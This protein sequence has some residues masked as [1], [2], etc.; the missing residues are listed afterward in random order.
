MTDIAS[1][2]WGVASTG[3]SSGVAVPTNRQTAALRFLG[4]VAVIIGGRDALDVSCG[5]CV[6]PRN[7]QSPLGEHTV[8]EASEYSTRS[9]ARAAPVHSKRSGWMRCA[10]SPVPPTTLGPGRAKYAFAFTA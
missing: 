6:P 3:Y 4:I 2:S 9:N 8:S 10:R 1:V 7:P 5:V